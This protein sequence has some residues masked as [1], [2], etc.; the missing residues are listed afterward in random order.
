MCCYTTT[1]WL[2]TSCYFLGDFGWRWRRRVIEERHKPWR[3]CRTALRH[4]M[5]QCCSTTAP[6]LV[7]PCYGSIF[8]ILS[9]RGL[10]VE[11]LLKRDQHAKIIPSPWA[12]RWWYL[13]TWVDF[14]RRGVV[15][16]PREVGM[17][18]CAGKIGTR[19]LDGGGIGSKLKQAELAGT[20]SMS[21]W[22]CCD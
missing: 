16:V 13:T 12:Y 17:A 10:N 14:V 6:W 8:G 15:G 7:T 2:L 11:F 9:H 21:G 20:E 3:H 19:L 4:A 22:Q 5:A 18:R 1:P